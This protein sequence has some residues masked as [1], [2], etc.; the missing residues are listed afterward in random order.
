MALSFWSMISPMVREVFSWV[1]ESSCVSLLTRSI[2]SLRR[3]FA[4]CSFSCWSRAFLSSYLR[5]GLRGTSVIPCTSFAEDWSLDSRMPICRA[6]FTLS[7]SS[8]SIS[9]SWSCIVI[10]FS[11]CSAYPMVF[12]GDV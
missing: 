5:L 10:C 11:S 4:R 1:A 2:S 7:F 8:L 6:S 9:S 3:S 12:K